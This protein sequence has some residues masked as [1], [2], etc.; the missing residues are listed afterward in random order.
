[1]KGKN[2][3]YQ[4]RNRKILSSVIILTIML[5]IIM[6]ENLAF[7]F[8]FRAKAESVALGAPQVHADIPGY[9]D[10]VYKDELYDG[11]GALGEMPR[12]LERVESYHPVKKIRFADFRQECGT[13][14][15]FNSSLASAKK[16]QGYQLMICNASD[17]YTLSCLTNGLNGTGVAEK[18]FYL[19]AEYILGNNIDFY[20]ESQLG[21][22]FLPIGDMD[23]KFTGAFEGQ[24]FEIRN[25]YFV[26]DL[27]VYRKAKFG[28]F[29]YAGSA[30]KIKNFGLYHPW[31]KCQINVGS[32]GV[33]AAVNEGQISDVY[34]I[35]DEYY[36][37]QINVNKLNTATVYATAGIAAENKASGLIRNCYFAGMIHTTDTHGI[38][39]PICPLNEGTI[40]N[41]YYDKDVYQYGVVYDGAGNP[42]NRLSNPDEN[43]MKGI[44][45]IDL[46]RVG[47]SADGM[48]NT[49]FKALRAGKTGSSYNN[50]SNRTEDWCYPRL[51]G[52]SGSGT[53]EDPFL[54]STPAQ[55]VNFPFSFEYYSDNK[56]YFRLSAD[57]DMSVA[58]ENIYRP[59]LMPEIVTNHVE[60]YTEGMTV[61]TS[62]AV[63]RE[64]AA[65]YDRGFYNNVLSGAVQEGDVNLFVHHD[66]GTN[67]DGEQ[68][69]ESH[70]IYGLGI[71]TPVSTPNTPNFLISTLALSDLTIRAK[72]EYYFTG[73]IALAQ[74]STISDLQMAGA[75][76]S[77]GEHDLL[78]TNNDYNRYNNGYTPNVYVFTS[79][80]VAY[81]KDTT[82]RN[83][84]NSSVVTLGTGRQFRTSMGGLVGGGRIAMAESC[85]NNGNILGRY[86]TMT[87]KSTIV[88]ESY[89]FGGLFGDCI[90]SKI[91]NCANHGNIMGTVLVGPVS[92]K[93]T[94]IWS[95][96]SYYAG[97][98]AGYLPNS[99]DRNVS[100]NTYNDGMIFDGPVVMNDNGDPLDTN[101]NAL[102][103]ESE[104][105]TL[106]ENGRPVVAP[107]PQVAPV[108]IEDYTPLDYH[109]ISTHRSNLADMMG[110]ARHRSNRSC[111][112]GKIYSVVRLKTSISGCG[113]RSDPST[114]ASNY[115]NLYVFSG[116]STVAGI[117]CTSFHSDWDWYSTVRNSYNKGSIYVYDG[118]VLVGGDDAHSLADYIC[119]ITP[120]SSVS[121][122]NE[123]HIYVAPSPSSLT[124]GIHVSGNAGRYGEGSN[125]NY[126]N[127]NTGRVTVDLDRYHF[128]FQQNNERAVSM[129][130]TGNRS[131]NVNY[132]ILEFIENTE[133]TKRNISLQMHAGGTNY[134]NRDG[135]AYYNVNYADVFV[136]APGN[137]LST[138]II[139]GTTYSN[140]NEYSLNVGDI[141]FRGKTNYLEISSLGRTNAGYWERSN[142]NLGNI[143]VTEDSV[144]TG[145][146]FI[147]NIYYTN[148]A[149]PAS[150]ANMFGWYEG[151]NYPVKDFNN[152]TKRL[153]EDYMSTSYFDSSKRCGVF[154]IS[155]TFGSLIVSAIHTN[156]FMHNENDTYDHWNVVNGEYNINNV[157]I[158]NNNGI[159]V[160]NGSHNLQMGLGVFGISM[161][162]M[163]DSVNYAPINVSNVLFDAANP[164]Q[165]VVAG[166]AGGNR[167]ANYADITVSNCMVSSAAR[168]YVP[169]FISGVLFNTYG[170]KLENHGSITVKNFDSAEVM[171][172]TY[173]RTTTDTTK[174]SVL[175]VVG[176]IGNQS[177][178]SLGSYGIDNAIN[179]GMISLEKIPVSSIAGGIAGKMNGGM[180]EC[181]NYGSVLSRNS[182]ICSPGGTLDF[183]NVYAGIVA[184]QGSDVT[185][186]Y[187]FAELQL[188]LPTSE[189]V[190][191]TTL[192]DD[193]YIGGIVG[194]S[195]NLRNCQNF[196][197]ILLAPGID[198]SQYS[199]AAI[200]GIIGCGG[201]GSVNS[202]VNYG[203]LHFMSPADDPIHSGNAADQKMSYAIGGITGIEKSTKRRSSV[204][205]YAYF[206][207]MSPAKL[208]QFTSTDPG[209]T[210]KGNSNVG[211]GFYYGG[212]VGLDVAGGSYSYGIN[213]G[214][215]YEREAFA[216]D[217]PAIDQAATLPGFRMGGL[218]GSIATSE[219][220]EAHYQHNA[221]LMAYRD[222]AMDPSFSLKLFGE[223]KNAVNMTP[224]DRI[225]P[226][227]NYSLYTYTVN[228]T[229]TAYGDSA[230][231]VKR[232]ILDKSSD[233]DR[234]VESSDGYLKGSETEG[235]FYANFVFRRKLAHEES[236]WS[237]NEPNMLMYTEFDNLSDY[238][239]DYFNFRFPSQDG[240]MTPVTFDISTLGAYVVVAGNSDLKQGYGGNS[241]DGDSFMP[242]GIYYEQTYIEK[243]NNVNVEK[244]DYNFSPGLS[245]GSDR[246]TRVP[247]EIEKLETPVSIMS[248]SA[249]P[250][251]PNLDPQNNTTHPNNYRLYDTL[252]NRLGLER[253]IMTDF[254]Y[255]AQQVRDSTMAEAYDSHT[256]S[257]MRYKNSDS[258]KYQYYR[259][260]IDIVEV[261]P[262][263]DKFNIPDVK[264]DDGKVPS[265]VDP[266]TGDKY[267]TA[268]DDVRYTDL[269]YFVALDDLD[270]TAPARYYISK[271]KYNGLSAEEQSGYVYDSS[272]SEYYKEV[273]HGGYMDFRLESIDL[274]DKSSAFYVLKCDKSQP[275]YTNYDN[276]SDRA[277]TIQND[278]LGIDTSEYWLKGHNVKEELENTE[279]WYNSFVANSHTDEETWKMSVPIVITTGSD[280]NPVLNTSKNVYTKIYGVQLS[281]DGKHYNIVRLNLVV[282]Y[283][284]PS[285]LVE[286]VRV[287][288]NNGV[289]YST[290]STDSEART[291]DI[292]FRTDE[293]KR[294]KDM[295]RFKED[296]YTGSYDNDGH[297]INNAGI[298]VDDPADTVHYNPQYGMA[299]GIGANDGLLA[300]KGMPSLTDT[301]L[302]YDTNG[303]VELNPDGTEKEVKRNDVTY[304]FLSNDLH[305]TD[306]ASNQKVSANTINFQHSAINY[307]NNRNYSQD[308]EI[309]LSTKNMVDESSASQNT[310][311]TTSQHDNSNLWAHVSYQDRVPYLEGY[312]YNQ[313]LK[314]EVVPDAN[315]KVLSEQLNDAS[316]WNDAAT[317]DDLDESK[318][319]ILNSISPEG[320]GRGYNLKKLR[321]SS[322]VENEATKQSTG[323]AKFSLS[324]A[325][326]GDI[327]YGGLY[328]VDLFYERSKDE[329]WTSAKHFATVFFWKEFET[330]N[331]QQFRHYDNGNLDNYDGRHSWLGELSLWNSQHNQY[332]N[333]ANDTG[334]FSSGYAL[335]YSPYYNYYTAMVNKNLLDRKGA[336]YVTSMNESG[337][338]E[339][340]MFAAPSRQ[341]LVND[342]FT[343]SLNRAGSYSPKAYT[344]SRRALLDGYSR[345][346]AE[347]LVYSNYST[348]PNDGRLVYNE[349]AEKQLQN[350]TKI[351][352]YDKVK[353]DPIFN[354]VLYDDDGNVIYDETSDRVYDKSSGVLYTNDPETPDY[355]GKTT[356][357]GEEYKVNKDSRQAEKVKSLSMKS[358][359]TRVD[360]VV[361]EQNGNFYPASYHWSGQVI[362]EDTR[363]VSNVVYEVI[364]GG[365]DSNRGSWNIGNMAAISLTN[366]GTKKN[367][368]TVTNG[369]GEIEG[370]ERESPTFT[371][372]WQSGNVTLFANGA[373]T[374]NPSVYN[375]TQQDA[376]TISDLFKKD[377]FGA[378]ITDGH[379]VKT[380]NNGN[381]VPFKLRVYYK[382]V[383]ET[384]YTELTESEIEDRLDTVSF[385]AQNVW[386]FKLKKYAPCG[387]YKF[388]PYFT[389]H[390]DLKMA[391]DSQDSI[392]LVKYNSNVS[393]E[394]SE[395]NKLPS[396]DY[397]DGSGAAKNVFEWTIAYTPFVI[398]SYPNDESYLEE[399]DVN[400]DNGMPVI[401]ESDSMAQTVAP[402]SQRDTYIIVSDEHNEIHYVGYENYET[403][404]PRIDK[405]DIT[406]FVG[407][408]DVTG[409]M[410]SK[411]SLT[412]KAPY[413]A[414]VEVWDETYGDSPMEIVGG[415]ETGRYDSDDA[416]W[417][418]MTDNIDSS[419]GEENEEFKHYTLPDQEYNHVFVD[420]P[421]IK[422]FTRYYRVI[423]EDQQT[424][425]LYRVN[426][427]P[428]R[429]NKKISFEIATD[430]N[431][432]IYET[433]I[434][435]NDPIVAE[436]EE[437][438]RVY[439]EL[440]DTYNQIFA[441]IKE[442]RLNEDNSVTI[443]NYETKWF[444][445][446]VPDV[447][448]GTS[449]YIYNLK[450]HLYDISASLPTGYTYDIYILSPNGDSYMSLLDSGHGFNGKK[451][452]MGNPD[453]QDFK[454][455]IVLKYDVSN[456]WGVNYVWTPDLSNSSYHD[457]HDYVI[458]YGG[459]ILN[460]FVY[461]QRLTS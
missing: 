363:N 333:N 216:A 24:G 42:Q 424:I 171:G 358:Q 422:Y 173:N 193:L 354:H 198:T 13:G 366:S 452:I 454:I 336:S 132:G 86:K 119:A 133:A 406:A 136:D 301:D 179:M 131:W 220:S 426:I 365:V 124:R 277:T 31:I 23:N 300:V 33:V 341:R 114:Y 434:A 177:N 400:N 459:G 53:Q 432:D 248:T 155:G 200:G 295:E 8:Q 130:C 60:P 242:D 39:H 261:H 144:V 191:K 246:K 243:E 213:Y 110:I 209:Y 294:V 149:R 166:A 22:Y 307:S 397:T 364:S 5:S 164:A 260:Y 118:A 382:S 6:P 386:T 227:Y 270:M 103:K 405:F 395:E 237:F 157:I 376:R 323:Y 430:V 440:S 444:D 308:V 413:R 410:T 342:S 312:D 332:V 343:Y 30:A 352:V 453:S 9:D 107:R 451:F 153:L 379:I 415:S 199:L 371:C 368:F 278:I 186:C 7:L 58:D 461:N 28:M 334:G 21:H 63:L 417:I 344:S 348:T 46:R 335:A 192:S 326:N 264:D 455:R 226:V 357:I 313:W 419:F 268:Y 44:S 143:L 32:V 64:W 436:Y 437:S 288:T 197:D 49:G 427:V 299:K 154:N 401:Y 231:N 408:D 169:F 257:A 223:L 255:F 374:Y 441:T 176:G 36:H 56:S 187:N 75:T 320:T 418:K 175:P 310:S 322:N 180:S 87:D 190:D 170:N 203:A 151:C 448:H 225:D 349:F 163:S 282:D 19:S 121:C 123:G 217:A 229:R 67:S 274:S 27:N 43:T 174:I 172:E 421:D 361:D 330:K 316:L 50:N 296:Y 72:D 18:Q 122:F 145:N 402:S 88:A 208:T 458:T 100:R 331:S 360:V 38:Q 362:S 445:G 311:T 211:Y 378:T 337:S 398:E 48:Q 325:F 293:T 259:D 324:D 269:F 420:D 250:N 54:I 104:E 73:L 347:S 389:Y 292:F 256:V 195:G 416:H 207:L 146:A 232:I 297:K 188:F 404:D 66:M 115:A 298:R 305:T 82:F 394:S 240:V 128:E 392:S 69:T 241:R 126:R 14:A 385:N 129:Q 89:F 74:N 97:I 291:S 370:D 393:T 90:V 85:T 102:S 253:T 41:C 61:N 70:V 35:V 139:T 328:R 222:N 315:H 285:A 224:H 390:T 249:F 414:T 284:K 346:G 286:A 45:S 206:Y 411:S 194:I 383:V 62:C 135:S 283:F 99:T 52:Y 412:F 80:L 425:T 147:Q 281:Q 381:D 202:V 37:S 125:Y 11:S 235:F 290:N 266:D 156:Y 165:A 152:T 447:V 377:G 375:Y 254:K 94:D 108:G 105:E 433:L 345:S 101:G 113:G 275:G 112:R 267:V 450:A 3:R 258:R 111:N 339:G 350:G 369:L 391:T 214:G 460:N 388:I 140:Y 181:I 446:S 387:S 210:L 439:E 34:V 384:E 329:G 184:V 185:N 183:R 435:N 84:H 359:L 429:R 134:Q 68:M 306:P 29:G 319:S 271:G 289:Y 263:R 161:D 212:L 236:E 327:Y 353:R 189:A 373:S 167:N 116:V 423:A 321:S 399:F 92:K 287:H 338:Q 234:N 356:I 77:T 273:D 20:E 238:L 438:R 196:G 26:S 247:S 442:L 428:S 127:I 309:W 76:V 55:L 304:Y 120:Y 201:N 4:R 279:K 182:G 204:V 78:K 215:Y 25:L 456:K 367:G 81:S 276:V 65:S 205:N 71:N 431:S 138:V 106:D 158:K 142:V 318:E 15:A 239:K 17:L 302:V 218:V 380:D 57:I 265:A 407:K 219:G 457:G 141:A 1:M 396:E 12:T 10:I 51:Y 47:F 83:V 303:E 137:S 178:N 159:N 245:T 251:S 355:N 272:L 221:D 93:L 280:G 98:C 148:G 233:V 91:R 351:P 372:Q 443:E 317:L 40:E 2:K 96:N 262:A 228:E 79:Q 95:T 314:D 244:T 117:A 168:K 16:A 162:R 403:G 109:G 340:M 160:N 449:P 252:L 150:Q 409:Q 59:Q 230:G